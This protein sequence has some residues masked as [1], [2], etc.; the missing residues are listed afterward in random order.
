MNKKNK[1]NKK[2]KDRFVYTSSE[3]LKIISKEKE[4]KK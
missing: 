2:K 1:K 3:G 4:E